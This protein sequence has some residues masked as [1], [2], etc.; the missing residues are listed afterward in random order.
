MKKRFIPI[1]CVFLVIVMLFSACNKE[2][3]SADETTVNTTEATTEATTTAV[4]T[5]ALP[6]IEYGV[7]TL[8]VTWNRGYVAAPWNKNAN[9][10]IMENADGF[11]YSDV[12][13]V[14]H[15]G[16]KIIFRDDDPITLTDNYQLNISLWNEV[17]GKWEMAPESKYFYGT[18]AVASAISKYENKGIVYTYVTAKNWENIRLCYASGATATNI[19]K[20]PTVTSEYTG[21]TS[22]LELHQTKHGDFF[23]WLES[24]K[25]TSYYK[26]LEGLTIN[27]LGDSYFEGHNMTNKHMYVWPAMLAQKYEMN[28]VNHGWNGSTVAIKP[29]TDYPNGRN[30]MCV[31]YKNLPDNDPD[32]VIIE[33]GRNDYSQGV[34]MG[35]DDS[36]DTSTF[37]GALNVLIN[38]VHEKYPNALIICVTLWNHTGNRNADNKLPND[39]GQAVIDLCAK[40]GVPCFNAL[41]QTMTKVYM[42]DANFRKTY[43]LAENDISHLNLDGMKL[44]LPAFEKFIGDEWAKFDG[45]MEIKN[46]SSSGPSVTPTP[47]PTPT[48]NPTPVVGETLDVTWNWGY[49]GSSSN[50][51]NSVNKIKE[52]ASYYSYSDIIVL[53]KAGTTITFVDDNAK[54]PVSPAFASGA[55]YVVSLWKQE[56]GAWVIDTTKT[57]YAGGSSIG[58]VN[59]NVTTYT[60][61]TTS[62]NECIR[63]CYR[64]GQT[65]NPTTIS[66]ATVTVALPSA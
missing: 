56:G 14:P 20:Y 49:V 46:V 52:N 63:L 29:A 53:E 35:T 11:S 16:T 40:R 2:E 18:K 43:C 28:F 48:P 54:D 25:D 24:T 39:Y 21:E 15:A 10:I 38:G 47:T 23:T 37:K 13:T 7:K 33:G 64:S 27:F 26:D 34:P 44:V 45:S 36:V 6:P 19:P 30:P 60:Y 61:T 12:I 17:D 32:I 50:Q 51:Q 31:R 8:D 57:Q 4:Q 42:T 58:Q 66:F 59:G 1:L 65:S 5:T 55:A 3:G 41:D 22:S 9:A 62:D